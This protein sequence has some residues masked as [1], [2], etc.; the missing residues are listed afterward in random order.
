MVVWIAEEANCRHVDAFN[1]I[2][3]HGQHVQP[4]S[5][6][7]FPKTAAVCSDPTDLLLEADKEFHYIKTFTAYTQK[8]SE[9]HL[10]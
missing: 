2:C 8:I 7:S 6:E 10:S 3:E 1:V 4:G 5:R 9:K